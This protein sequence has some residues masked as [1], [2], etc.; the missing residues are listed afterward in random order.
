MSACSIGVGMI[1]ILR[2]VRNV[3]AQKLYTTSK[4][5]IKEDAEDWPRHT[6]ARAFVNSL[7]FHIRIDLAFHKRQRNVIPSFALSVKDPDSNDELKRPTFRYNLY[8]H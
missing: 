5:S 6:C 4:P 8:N 7:S 2:S 1:A 3:Y